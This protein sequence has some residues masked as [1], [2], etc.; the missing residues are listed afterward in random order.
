M[1]AAKC[2]LCG[3]P[4]E[5][6]SC[7]YCGY[8]EK[9]MNVQGNLGTDLHQGEIPQ[10]HLNQN[11]NMQVNINQDILRGVSKKNKTVTLLLAIFL[12]GIGAHRFYVGKGGTGII[13]LL[14]VGVFGIGWII[15]IIM[16][17]TG[18]FKDEFELPI[19]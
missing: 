2:P 15:D 10:P 1:M 18:R 5:N 8:K 11:I 3:A 4:M 13:Y 12:G 9:K 7:G 17:A 6:E 19:Q 14:T 16:I